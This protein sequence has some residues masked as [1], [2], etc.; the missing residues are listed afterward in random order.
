MLYRRSNISSILPTPNHVDRPKLLRR[1]V[2][3]GKKLSESIKEYIRY[4]GFF[5]ILAGLAFGSIQLLKT[6]LGTDY[7]IMVVVSQS[8]VPTLNV[9]DFIVIGGIQD[10]DQVVAAPSPEGDILVFSRVGSPDSYIVHRAIDKYIQQNEWYFTTK[11]DNNAGTDHQPA[12]EHNVEGKVVG[13]LPI[14]GY[15]PLFIKTSRGFFLVATL[16]IVI[17]FADNILR[18]CVEPLNIGYNLVILEVAP[19]KDASLPGVHANVFGHCAVNRIPL[20][21]DVANF[22][23]CHSGAPATLIGMMQAQSPNT[24]LG[25]LKPLGTPRIIIITRVR[26]Q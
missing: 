10:F 13:N 12:I 20:G 9:G 8:M 11:G 16:M 17:F 4:L 21:I 3:A 26:N 7:P 23:H 2:I 14:M 24:I 18:I 19:I 15:F 6:T 25:V 22:E 5:V 1:I